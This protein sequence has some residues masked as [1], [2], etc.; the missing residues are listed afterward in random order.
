M[1]AAET[2]R[3]SLAQWAFQKEIFEKNK[4]GAQNAKSRQAHVA[5]DF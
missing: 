4:F 5:P 2:Q 3:L 1:V